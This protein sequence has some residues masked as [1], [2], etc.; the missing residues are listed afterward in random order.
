M[1][2]H[3]AEK[4]RFELKHPSYGEEHGRV[5]GHERRAWEDLVATGSIEI[6]ETP[7]YRIPAPLR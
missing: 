5:I 4:Y 7:A 6:K 3:L 1:L 2:T